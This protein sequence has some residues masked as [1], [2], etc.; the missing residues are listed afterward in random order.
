METE[1]MTWDHQEHGN[2]VPNRDLTPLGSSF[3]TTVRQ[4]VTGN[5]LEVRIIA[6]TPRHRR[7][8][9]MAVMFEPYYKILHS[10][11]NGAIVIQFERVLARSRDNPRGHQEQGN[12]ALLR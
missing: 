2:T 10:V 8:G 4:R 12:P 11:D 5:I 7:R 1:V 6:N 9:V 3:P